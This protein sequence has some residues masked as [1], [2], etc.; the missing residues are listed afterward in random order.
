MSRG[1][2]S[3]HWGTLVAGAGKPSAPQASD[4]ARPPLLQC[5]PETECAVARPGAALRLDAVSRH[6][7]GV[8][9]VVHRTR[10]GL[11]VQMDAGTPAARAEYEIASDAAG[12][13]G[14]TRPRDERCL[15]GT[16]PGDA[17]DRVTAQHLDP[18]RGEFGD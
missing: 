11:R 8:G 18:A 10:P 4:P 17:D 15:H 5:G 14:P 6:E 13:S 1:G 16:A 7:T 3:E 12:F 9:R 2:S